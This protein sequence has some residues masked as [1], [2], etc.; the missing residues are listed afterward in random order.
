MTNSLYLVDF[1]NL[2]YRLSRGDNSVFQDNKTGLRYH[3]GDIKGLFQFIEKCPSNTIYFALDGSPTYC[4]ALVPSY[5]MNRESY[6]KDVFN[7]N[8]HEK[9]KLC[10]CH[11]EKCGK[12][13]KVIGIA[14]CEAD[15]TISS[16]VTIFKTPKKIFPKSGRYL[17]QDTYFEKDFDGVRNVN[18]RQA[19]FNFDEI[20]IVS[21]DSDLYQLIGENIYIDSTADFKEKNNIET[22]KT[23][24]NVAP[25]LIPVY[26]VFFGDKT[27]NIKGLL[28]GSALGVSDFVNSFTSKNDIDSFLVDI[29]YGYTSKVAYTPFLE[30][31]KNHKKLKDFA[32]LLEVFRLDYFDFPRM[33]E[34]S[35][36]DYNSLCE[37]YG[38]IS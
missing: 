23:V 19:D 35:P 14:D 22:I 15:Q 18:L 30:Y 5:K 7:I 21:T 24:S 29:K 38:L 9:L 27:D 25:Y 31:I 3:L 26:K 12:I 11:A 17:Q 2:S 37:K 20:V 10:M 28:E 16:F 36:N 4:R 33:L 32:T 13:L 8:L 34:I 1:N 6:Q